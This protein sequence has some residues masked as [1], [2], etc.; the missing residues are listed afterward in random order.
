V[1]TIELDDVEIGG[2]I[3]GDWLRVADDLPMAPG[4]R[5]NLIAQIQRIAS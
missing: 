3:R 2:M 4:T 1:A 5:A